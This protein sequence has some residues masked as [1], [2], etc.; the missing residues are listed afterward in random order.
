M[1]TIIIDEAT[2]RALLEDNSEDTARAI[3][4]LREL[5]LRDAVLDLE[6]PPADRSPREVTLRLPPEAYPGPRNRAERR[7]A[8]AEAR[9]RR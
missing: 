5:G 6:W 3:R 4:A 2:G 8:A 7:K 1:T 9:R